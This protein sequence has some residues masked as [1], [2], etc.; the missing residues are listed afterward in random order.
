MLADS[1]RHARLL[2]VPATV[3]CHAVPFTFPCCI[4]PCMHLATDSSSSSSSSQLLGFA[5]SAA[6]LQ[7]PGS[8]ICTNPAY[9]YTLHLVCPLT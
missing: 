8:G 9:A 7:V 2:T 6:V 1:L 4:Q 5:C 3:F